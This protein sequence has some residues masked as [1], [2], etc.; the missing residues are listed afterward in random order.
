MQFDRSDVWP[1]L[2][3]SEPPEPPFKNQDLSG[4]SLT[5]SVPVSPAPVPEP[6]T[7]RE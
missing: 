4:L 3:Q 7:E 5:H 2:H 1:F 6:L